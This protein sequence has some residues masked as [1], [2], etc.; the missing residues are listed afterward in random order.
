MRICIAGAGKSGRS[1]AR[2]LIVH[3]HEVLLIDRDPA[4]IKPSSVPT[5]EWLLADACELRTLAEA[6]LESCDVAVAATGD[7]KAN[8]VYSLLAKT[9]FA[10]PRV[11]ARINHPNNEWLFD[12]SWG[13][14]VAVSAPRLLG[15]LVD[16][17]V[18]AADDPVRVLPLQN[19][20]TVLLELRVP[21]TNPWAGRP[22]SDLQ[23]DLASYPGAVFVAL[24]RDG[25]PLPPS[26]DSRIG[27]G[28]D[29]V[30]LVSHDAQADLLRHLSGRK[31]IKPA[32]NPDEAA[33]ADA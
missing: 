25:Q 23:T 2:E 28:D 22:I 15:A 31:E 9:E 29:V 13:V 27:V 11:V 18:L 7:D 5:A 21:E 33:A 10:I 16:E 4:H 32:G 26:P 20:Q 1:I 19:P 3:G 8:L 17:A 24:I 30:Y 12:Q 6:H 14:D